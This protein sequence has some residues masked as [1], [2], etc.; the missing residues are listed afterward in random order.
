MSQRNPILQR[1]SVNT[2]GRDFAVGDIHGCFSKLETALLRARFSPTTDRLFAVGDLVDRGPE[3]HHA[4]I[5]LEYP[6]FHAICGN[7]DLMTWRRASGDP[8]PRVDHTA[9]GG[10]W[11]DTHDATERQRIAQSL[12]ALPLAIE[13]ETAQGMIGIVHGDYPYDDWQAIQGERLSAED[14]EICLW[15]SDRYRAQY[16]QPV[17]NVRAIVHG[18]LTLPRMAQLGNVFYIDTGG[19]RDGGQF[20]LLD[21][22]TL[23]AVR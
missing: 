7:H 22:H 17:R 13:V 18:H 12:R 1:F 21:L 3:S 10:K 6:W 8:Y 5:W 20:T 2:A 15:S 16:T 9:H 14:E 11:L 19:W 23:K 4:L